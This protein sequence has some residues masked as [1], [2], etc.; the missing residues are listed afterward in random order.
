LKLSIIILTKDESETIGACVLSVLKSVERAKSAGLVDSAEVI[1]VDSASTDNTIEIARSFPI[2]I[3][4]LSPDIPLSAG[5]GSYVGTQFASGGILGIVNGD[6]VLDSDWL[7]ESLPFL[8]GKVGAVLG[9][10]R[11]CFSGA[12]LAERMLIRTPLELSPGFSTPERLS[13][14]S[15]GVSAGTMLLWREAVDQAGSYNPFLVA[16]EDFDLRLRIEALGYSVLNIPVVQGDHHAKASGGSLAL[17]DLLRTLYRNSIGLGQLLR[18]RRGKSGYVWIILRRCVSLTATWSILLAC[19]LGMLA[20]AVVVEAILG[21]VSESI[22]FV[23][24]LI[25]LLIRLSGPAGG[26]PWRNRF[27][28]RFYPGLQALI[29]VAGLMNGFVRPSRDATVYPVR[30]EEIPTRSPSP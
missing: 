16:A 26:D 14:H 23:G 6:M 28:S 22:A 29:R 17:S 30:V 10:A 18:W 27:L 20:A 12:S 4:R 3:L 1:L 9:I 21:R 19:V 8:T 7:A 25:A 15:G 13:T 5:A 11:E 2:R 24:A